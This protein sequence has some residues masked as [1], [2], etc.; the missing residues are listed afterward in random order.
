MSI[1]VESANLIREHLQAMFPQIVCRRSYLPIADIEQLEDAGTPIILVVPLKRDAEKFTSGGTQKNDLLFDVAVNA[2]LQHRNDEPETLLTEIDGYIEIVETIHAAFLKKIVKNTEG[3][4]LVC[5]DPD[6]F[7]LSDFES[8][9]DNNCFL[10]LIRVNA[11]VYQIPNTS[12]ANQNE[13]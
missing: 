4:R 9:H 8:I 6:H 3:F 10:S 2:K 12:N 7:I 11:E 1:T 13:S 5:Q